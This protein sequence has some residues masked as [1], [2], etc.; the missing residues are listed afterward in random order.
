M[1]SWHRLSQASSSTL[2]QDSSSRRSVSWDST[3]GRGGSG[4]D[5][6]AYKEAQE[7]QEKRIFD[8]PPAARLCQIYQDEI[9]QLAEHISHNLSPMAETGKLIKEQDPAAKIVFIGPCTA[10][11]GEV[12]KPEVHQYVD[13]VMT[14]FEEL[15]AMIDSKRYRRGSAAGNRARYCYILRKSLCPHRRSK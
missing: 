15:Q 11:K 4:A 6:V 12:R 7:L 3:R 8:I 9:P 1:P 13:Y 14:F 10:K 5:I 2:R